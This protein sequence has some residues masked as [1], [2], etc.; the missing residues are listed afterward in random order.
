MIVFNFRIV[1]PYCSYKLNEL[2]GESSLTLM[3]VI[4]GV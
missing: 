2:G 3:T 1:T 4:L